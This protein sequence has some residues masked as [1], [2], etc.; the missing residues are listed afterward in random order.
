VYERASRDRRRGWMT[1]GLVAASSAGLLVGVVV[2]TPDVHPAKVTGA[3][4]PSVDEPTATP[5]STPAPET[6]TVSYHGIEVVVPAS[7]GLNA[8]EC[9]TPMADTVMIMEGAS[10]ACLVQQPPG[11]TVMYL[12]PSSPDSELVA[13]ATEALTVGGQPARRGLSSPPQWREATVLWLPDP[14]VLVQIESPHPALVEELIA[15]IRITPVD[16][17]GCVDHVDPLPPPPASDQPLG[18]QLVPGSPTSASI[19]RYSANWL[20]RSE[21]L[22]PSERDSLVE[23]FNAL[24]AGTSKPGPGFFIVPEACLDEVGR[25]FLVQFGYADG[26]HVEVFVDITG[27]TDLFA[28]NGVRVTKLNEAVVSFLMNRVG[29]DGG[30][31]NPSELQ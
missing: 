8:S 15:G 7:F 10:P 31:P 16:S 25:G 30:F 12:S 27:C 2:L 19:C 24:P 4:F 20:S 18:G 13:L 26:D 28:T 22:D 6:R 11:L 21:V 14:G 5:T 29:Y 17:A 3:A 23:L 1:V 9:G